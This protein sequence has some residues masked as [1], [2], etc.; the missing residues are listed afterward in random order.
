MKGK[1]DL[2]RKSMIL[3]YPLMLLLFV[4]CQK[5]SSDYLLD[6]IQVSEDFVF[7]GLEWHTSYDDVIKQKHITEDDIIVDAMDTRGSFIT[8]EEIRFKDLDIPLTAQYIFIDKELVAG[9]YHARIDEEDYLNV[10]KKL[11][12]L[13]TNELDD[14]K[15]GNLDILLELPKL[16]SST[17]VSWKLGKGRLSV[18]VYK[19]PDLPSYSLLINLVSEKID[20]QVIDGI[21]GK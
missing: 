9:D 2:S 14:P 7:E 3:L 12:E 19:Y 17:S 13:F 5:N 4:A 8:K 20:Q 15:E 10:G 16:G 11:Y 1:S 18:S 6:S 21:F